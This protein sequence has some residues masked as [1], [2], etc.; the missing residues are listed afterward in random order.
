M[1]LRV[2]QEDETR[3]SIILPHGVS[4]GPLR[5]IVIFVDQDAHLH[6]GEPMDL[7][8]GDEV[9]FF[10]NKATAFRYDGEE[11]WLIHECGVIAT[12]SPAPVYE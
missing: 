4:G 8:P 10:T 3:G 1:I 5:G 6:D 12:T 11:L 2:I 7:K 9:L